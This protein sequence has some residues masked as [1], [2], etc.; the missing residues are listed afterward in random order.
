LADAGNFAFDAY[1]TA[2]AGET[3]SNFGAQAYAQVASAL[4][5][6]GSKFLAPNG[7][8]KSG[9]ANVPLGNANAGC[10]SLQI[11]IT[12][13]GNK[14]AGSDRPVFEAQDAASVCYQWV[15]TKELHIR[16]SS[17]YVDNVKREW[18]GGGSDTVSIRYM[19]T[20]GCKWRPEK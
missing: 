6:K 9:A 16:I 12:K 5:L 15:G 19:G 17:G 8:S 13:R 2:V 20:D 14:I 3:Y 18:M 10:P 4:G 7:M 1:V 11:Y